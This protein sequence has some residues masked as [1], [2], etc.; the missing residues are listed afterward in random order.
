M[1]AGLLLLL[2]SAPTLRA[3][4]SVDDA[5]KLMRERLST[6]PAS[7]QPMSEADQLREENN[8]LREENYDLRQQVS[9]LHEALEHILHA[10][11]AGAGPATQPAPVAAAKPDASGGPDI[12][13]HYRG[14]SADNGT[15]FLV[16]FKPD[17]TYE[18]DWFMP[19][20]TEPGHYQ[21]D[22]DG[23]IEMWS[24]SAPATAPHHLW[25]FV[26]ED[27]QITLTPLLANGEPSGDPPQVLTKTEK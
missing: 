8:R 14:G 5:Q 13:G 21:F 18:Q 2:A 16:K 6:R 24:D 15:A 26:T 23:E 12:V 19:A 22:G 25:K 3:Q 7:T 4:M 27:N 9:S 20:R 10:S 17:G 1:I 11:P